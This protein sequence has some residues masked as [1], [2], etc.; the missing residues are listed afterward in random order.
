[1]TMMEC[2]VIPQGDIN[3]YIKPIEMPEELKAKFQY[4]TSAQDQMDF[5]TEIAKGNNEKMA[6]Y[7][8]RLI[9]EGK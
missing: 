5:I 8:R 9:K 4:Y 1:M 6:E 2:G 3:D 7:V